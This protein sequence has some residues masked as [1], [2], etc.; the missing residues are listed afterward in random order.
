MVAARVVAATAVVASAPD[1]DASVP[2]VVALAKLP[3]EA[4]TEAATEVDAAM[5]AATMGAPPAETGASRGLFFT[6]EGSP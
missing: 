1:V 6:V 3:P 4:S 2:A 5:A